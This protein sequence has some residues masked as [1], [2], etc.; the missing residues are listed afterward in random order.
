MERTIGIE[1][2]WFIICNGSVV[3][4]IGELLP[5]LWRE[6]KKKRWRKERFGWELFAG[7]LEE[8]TPPASSIEELVGYLKENFELMETVCGSLGFQLICK[9]FVEEK[10]LGELLVNPFD[11]RHEK[12]WSRISEKRRVAA[13]QVAAIHVHV[14][15]NSEEAVKILSYC[16][17]EIVDRLCAL[18]DFSCGRRLRSYKEMA[19]VSGEPPVFTSFEEI[20]NYIDEHGGE[21]NVWDLVRYKPFSTETI[22]F[23]MF[24]ATTDIKIIEKIIQACMK[25]VEDALAV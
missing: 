9:D 21:R 4:A 14:S 5:V 10:D 8:R 11:K 20:L 23:R 17:R 3:P 12:I 16:R 15:T 18:G 2:G 25:V 24:G 6:A 19:Q 7:Q 13:S 22:E 1:R